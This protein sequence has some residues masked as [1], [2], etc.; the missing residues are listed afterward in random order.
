MPVHNSSLLLHEL[1]VYS[2]TYLSLNS[3]EFD[4]H[5]S[6][7]T[8]LHFLSNTESRS[9]RVLTARWP[10]PML[11]QLKKRHTHPLVLLSDPC[12]VSSSQPASQPFRAHVNLQAVLMAADCCLPM[13]H[14][15]LVTVFPTP[16]PVVVVPSTTWRSFLPPYITDGNQP[17]HHSSTLDST[18]T[19]TPIHHR[20]AQRL[21][22]LLLLPLPF[23]PSMVSPMMP[24]LIMRRQ[25]RSL[26]RLIRRRRGANPAI[27]RADIYVASSQP[28]TSHRKV[29]IKMKVRVGGVVVVDLVGVGLHVVD[30]DEVA[31]PAPIQAVVV[32]VGRSPAGEAA[33]EEGEEG[34]QDEEAEHA[35]DDADDGRCGEGVVEVVLTG[36]RYC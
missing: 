15:L 9:R 30:G 29:A 28:T 35:D 4:S 16:F 27:Q 26:W 36:L 17:H 18:P 22:L 8:L 19:P 21:L 5:S 10:P 6:L 34:E 24:R 2:Q 12:T 33:V 20:R 1:I 7:V 13:P 14:C 23:R 25:V 31:V 32:A 3:I 11:H